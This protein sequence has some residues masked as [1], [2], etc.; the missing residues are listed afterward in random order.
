MPYRD[1]I[2]PDGSKVRTRVSDEATLSWYKDRDELRS[3]GYP[4]RPPDSDTDTMRAWCGPLSLKPK[5]VEVP[6]TSSI[7]I[8][9]YA[10]TLGEGMP[11]FKVLITS[12][13][14]GEGW[15]VRLKMESGIAETMGRTLWEG[16]KLIPL[17]NIDLLNDAIDNAIEGL[18][19]LEREGR[20][21]A[22]A[23]GMWGWDPRWLVSGPL[24]TKQAL[25]EWEL[26]GE[27]Y[28][29]EYGDSELDHPYFK[30]L[31]EGDEHLDLEHPVH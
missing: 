13:M 8:G 3:K 22:A 4:D 19:D 23:V 11:T 10:L 16:E 28:H 31:I 5:D 27:E 14:P 7:P 20:H 30:R 1:F 2:L 26:A 25:D 18:F 21:M 6:R 9:H 12:L 17:D 15:Y 24:D 29:A